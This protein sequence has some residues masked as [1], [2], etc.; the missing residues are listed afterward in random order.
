[1][2]FSKIFAIILF[3]RAYNRS[4]DNI[5]PKESKSLKFSNFVFHKV[6]T[7]EDP[8]IRQNIQTARVFGTDS[9][10]STL[11][12]ASRSI[13]SWDILVHRVSNLV[14]YDKR[15]ASDIDLQTVH[16][17]ASEPAFD[18]GINSPTSLSLES[19]T[20]NQY[21]S[22]QCLL[23]QKNE[24]GP[25][26]FFNNQDSSLKP[27]VGYKYRLFDLGDGINAL[28]RCEFDAYSLADK[29]C[30]NIKSLLEWGTKP[31]MQNWRAEFEN[32]SGSTLAGE[33]K[34]N[35][36]KIA[37]WTSSAIM[38]GDHLL[39][40]GFIS[41]NHYANN[42]DHSIIG[43]LTTNSKDLANQ[44]GLSMNNAWGILYSLS[45]K[46]LELPEGKYVIFKDPQKVFLF[47]KR[48]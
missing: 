27:S 34:N 16:E 43:S 39:K 38:A 31:Q 4:Y 1:M 25:N 29:S 5:K 26:P 35:S 47:S 17:T 28:I 37:K 22:Q 40:I 21:Y 30:I 33:I 48:R 8:I 9:I 19:S 44:I 14:F 20:V 24:Y 2:T 42:K 3:I 15:P 45:K 18:H 11:M 6:C 7:C 41:R 23:P 10:I 32:Y 13:A 12:S 46:F 36:C